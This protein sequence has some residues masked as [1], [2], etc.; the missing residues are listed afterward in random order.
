MNG[1]IST[2]GK[3][4]G[5]AS[6]SEGQTHKKKK[7]ETQKNKREVTQTEPN[8]TGDI[9]SRASR[10]LCCVQAACFMTRPE[11]AESKVHARERDQERDQEGDQDK[12]RAALFALGP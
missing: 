5:C 8:A 11:R 12:H 4:E 7:T 2:H 6:S 10:D 3:A 9:A 1:D